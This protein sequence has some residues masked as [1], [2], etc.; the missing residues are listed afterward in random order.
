MSTKRLQ[1]LVPESLDRRIRKAAQRRRLAA[2]AWVREAIER[3]LR[4]DQPASDPLERLKAL[5]SPTADLDQMLAE[6]EAGRGQ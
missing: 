2:G 6:I 5:G 1:V 3:H 4:D